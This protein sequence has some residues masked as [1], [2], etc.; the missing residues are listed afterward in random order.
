MVSEFKADL[1]IL[2]HNLEVSILMG[3]I[4]EKAPD[5]LLC[6]LISTYGHTTV[7]AAFLEKK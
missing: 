7:K 4:D 3:F 5:V 2:S 1:T 6:G